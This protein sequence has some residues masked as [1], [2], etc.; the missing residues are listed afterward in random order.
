M[1]RWFT[2]GYAAVVAVG[3]LL[4]G[5]QVALGATTSIPLAGSAADLVGTAVPVPTVDATQVVAI[6]DTRVALLAAQATANAPTST[7]LPTNV[8]TATATVTPTPLPGPDLALG[9]AASSS[10]SAPDHG[11]DLAVDGDAATYWLANGPAAGAIQKTWSV[12]L[13]GGTVTG[14]EA[15]FYVPQPAMV[16]WSVGVVYGPVD[17]PARLTRTAS[18]WVEDHTVVAMRF[19]PVPNAHQVTMTFTNVPVTPGL[20]SVA[21]RGTE[22]TIQAA[23]RA[24]VPTRRP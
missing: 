23:G 8:P 15:T 14:V 5:G 9:K 1:K 7:P 2:N 22:A 18:S 17:N 16:E 6:V 13:D 11:P 21:V 20:R 4:V 3:L 24:P 19:D 12:L 10:A